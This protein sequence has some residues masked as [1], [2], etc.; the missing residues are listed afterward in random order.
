MTKRGWGVCSKRASR[1]WRAWYTDRHGRQKFFTGTPSK[2]QTTQIA[3]E[4]ALAERALRI[5]MDLG[6]PVTDYAAGEARSFED[7]LREYLAWGSCQGG[8]RGGPW[9]T[10]HRRKT[11]D[12]LRWWGE[13]IPVQTI[14]NLLHCLPHV[15]QALRALKAR[16]RKGKTLASYAESL[17]AFC[18][19]CRSRELLSTDPLANLSKFD[20]RPQ[21][22]WRAFTLEEIAQL[23]PV[24]Q[25]ERQ[26]LYRTAICTGLRRNELSSLRAEHLDTERGGLTLDAVWTKNREPGFQPLPADLMADLVA[27]AQQL[28][29]DRPILQ[30]P[31]LTDDAINRDLKRA[32]IEKKSARGVLV[33]HSFRKTF[34]T[35]L[36]Q[37]GVHMKDI[38]ALTRHQEILL[39]A[40][41][42]TDIREDD[43]RSAVDHLGALIERG[44]MQNLCTNR[45]TG[46]HGAAATPT[47]PT[48][49]ATHPLVPRGGFEPHLPDIDNAAAC[50][51]ID[52]SIAATTRSAKCLQHDRADL[53][54]LAAHSPC[55]SSEKN[56]AD[57]MQADLHEVAD[58]WP[59]LPTSTRARILAIARGSR[60]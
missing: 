22:W 40:T 56:Y 20:K 11:E 51:H 12:R 52:R 27:A 24:C 36:K 3:Q 2:S 19:W 28:P 49:K 23:L 33:F 45:A 57:S 21:T 54:A 59:T 38:S 53:S 50:T 41:R 46:T 47:A 48:R 16:G 15:E 30:V 34:A 17:H 35:L 42:Y 14:S 6:L 1:N 7:V 18:L 32:G 25:A 29:G 5:R 44:T 55:N 39:T 4:K 9:G 10:E 8:L 31:K 60:G 43:L 58:R 26:L 37:L 13:R